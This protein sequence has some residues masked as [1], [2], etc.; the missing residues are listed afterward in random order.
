ME[1]DRN[2]EGQWEAFWQCKFKHM[3]REGLTEKVIFKQRLEGGEAHNWEDY[4]RQ[5]EQEGQRPGNGNMAGMFK[6]HK[7]SN[8][9]ITV[10][11]RVILAVAG[12]RGGEGGLLRALYAVVGS[13]AFTQSETE[14]QGSVLNRGVI[15]SVLTGLL[16]PLCG[17]Q[18]KQ[19]QGQKQKCWLG[20]GCSSPRER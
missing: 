20:G 2:E 6:E 8:G 4:F 17:G 9:Q 14:G 11:K 7:E 18:T 13:L 15:G 16:C 5:W 19:G 12:W 10:R 1:N 3:V